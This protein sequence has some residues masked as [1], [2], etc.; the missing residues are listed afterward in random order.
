MSLISCEKFPAPIPDRKIFSLPNDR[1][2]SKTA[3]TVTL[4]MYSV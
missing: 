1:L 2:P 4:T 3:E